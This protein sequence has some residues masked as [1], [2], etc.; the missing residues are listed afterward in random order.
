MDAIL[1]AEAAAIDINDLPA[2]PENMIDKDYIEHFDS[3]ED[4]DGNPK[5]SISDYESGPN[6]ESDHE[7]ISDA[8]IPT[9]PPHKPP[10]RKI[11]NCTFDYIVFIY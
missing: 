8:E 7:L 2:A 4:G 10:V 3:A 9:K 5:I 6:P 1:Q 11:D